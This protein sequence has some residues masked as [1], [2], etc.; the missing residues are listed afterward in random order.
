VNEN[1]ASIVQGLMNVFANGWQ[2][3]EKGYFVGLGYLDVI[4]LEIEVG[5]EGS[6]R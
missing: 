4:V 2:C 6:R 3:K 1:A 5:W